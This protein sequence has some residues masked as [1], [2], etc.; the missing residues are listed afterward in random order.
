MPD[1][2][3]I[4]PG[5]GATIATDDVGGR[6]FQ[7]VKPAFGA[8]G[9]ASDVSS[10]NPLPITDATNGALVSA[11]TTVG[12]SAT[13]LPATPAS[14]R[15]RIVIQNLSDDVVYVGSASVTTATGLEIAS[16][17]SLTLPLGSAII[18]GR[19]ATGTADVRTLEFPS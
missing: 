18:Y 5:V 9:S 7:R 10:A 13:P 16:R 6:H 15:R 11:A 12:T 4:T 19:V 2:V 3:A 8:D 1:D 17:G 14:G